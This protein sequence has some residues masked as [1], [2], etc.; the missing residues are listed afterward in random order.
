[1]YYLAVVAVCL[2]FTQSAFSAEE[3]KDEKEE[4]DFSWLDPEKKISV[5]QNR[6]YTK[7]RSIELGIAG[8]IGIGEAYRTTRVF[9]PRAT[10]YFNE[11]FGATVLGAFVGNSENDNMRALR[12]ASA[13]S[14]PNIRDVR[15]WVGGGVVWVPFYAKLNI[16]NRIFYMDWHFDAGLV[17][18]NSEIDL[19]YQAAGAANYRSSSH[20]GF[21]W[22]TAQK[23]FIT[24]NIA[25]RIDFHNIYYSA[26]KAVSG[27]VST[28]TVLNTHY[29]L[30]LGA[31]YTF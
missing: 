26:P 12:E 27:V 31:S 16:F 10:Y 6:K 25:A 21:Y 15:S 22:G 8:G 3:E 2:V 20:T 7:T 17:Q 28:A 9:I 5:V 13:S 30:T 18:V 24:K 4:Y 11:S 19:N 14:F 1:L 29:Y 23:F